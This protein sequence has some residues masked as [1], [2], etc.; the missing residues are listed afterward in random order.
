M[1]NRSLK[2][3]TNILLVMAIILPLPASAVSLGDELVMSRL[4]D[5]VEIEI[6]VLQW[7]DLDMDRVQIGVGTPAEYDAFGL[8]RLPVLDTLSF[9]LIGPDSAGRVTLLV[10][11]REPVLEPFLELLMVIR[12]P[13]GSLLREYVLL[14]D[15][16]GLEQ[17]Q[18]QVTELSMTSEITEPVSAA[19]ANG[20]VT[21]VETPID[22]EAVVIEPTLPP[23]T[24]EPEVPS[25]RNQ[26]A[27][28]VAPV[29]TVVPPRVPSAEAGQTGRQRYQV[30]SGDSLWDIAGS[31]QQ[32]NPES[33][34]YLFL[35][36]LHD[37][38]RD[39]FINGNISLLKS[40]SMLQIPTARDM[41]L[42]NRAAARQIFEQRWEEGTERFTLARQGEALPLFSEVYANNL[43]ESEVSPIAAEP[44]LPAGI[45]STDLREEPGLLMPASDTPLIA[46]ATVIDSP[47]LTQVEIEA[48]TEESAT[49]E[50]STAPVTAGNEQFASGQISS[51]TA[52]D[53]PQ[54]QNPALD[55]VTETAMQSGVESP[56]TS[57]GQ[58]SVTG[59]SEVSGTT[60][61][62][63]GN[64]L[65]I[66]LAQYSDNPYL[67]GIS[68]NARSI[69]LLLSVRQERLDNIAENAITR[70]YAMEQARAATASIQAQLVLLQRKSGTGLLSPQTEKNLALAMLMLTLLGTGLIIRETTLIRARY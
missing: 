29:A 34:L 52:A 11:N 37:L 65:L 49:D 64:G 63:S 2:L 22:P 54:T 35:V 46:T 27:I 31:Y 32:G 10:S 5:P 70:D 40:G 4:G 39:A 44:A 17:P 61:P 12:W 59:I 3:L 41:S 47:Q 20:P 21:V 69:Q 36:S 50:M 8:Q 18:E 30:Q 66:N 56:Q 14:F 25:I 45:E 28:D 58:E 68:E 1:R 33:D 23:A 38:N 42:I 55:V 53:S 60:A 13:G 24:T 26:L 51:V 6:E 7:Q 16:P 62:V 9:N 67:S 43:L 48:V 15:P 57:T 19:V